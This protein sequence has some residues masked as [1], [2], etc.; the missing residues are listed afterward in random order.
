LIIF[1]S[2]HYDETGQSIVVAKNKKRAKYI[3]QN[4]EEFSPKGEKW[5]AYINDDRSNLTSDNI[6]QIVCIGFSPLDECIILDNI[7]YG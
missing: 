2:A 6:E 1:K 4:G 7:L 5:V 3:V